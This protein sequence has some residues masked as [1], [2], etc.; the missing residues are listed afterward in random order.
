M[1]DWVAVAAR[2][3]TV[4]RERN[5]DAYCSPRLCSD[6]VKVHVERRIFRGCFACCVHCWKGGQFVCMS[7][8]PGMLVVRAL[9]CGSR[10]C[11]C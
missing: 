5:I 6:L 3:A 2:H 4:S 11:S 8:L 1:L 10:C 9:C 7:G